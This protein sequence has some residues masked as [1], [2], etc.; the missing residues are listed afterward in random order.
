MYSLCNCIFCTFS[1]AV[2]NLTADFTFVNSSFG[3]QINVTWDKHLK[4]IG[5]TSTTEIGLLSYPLP[6]LIYAAEQI[7]VSTVY[8]CFSSLKIFT[9]VFDFTRPLE[10]FFIKRKLCFGCRQS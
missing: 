6:H 7:N 3:W 10:V 4:H 9:T 2:T 5:Y 1:D 8:F